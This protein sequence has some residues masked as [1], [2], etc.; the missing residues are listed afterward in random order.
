MQDGN[1][2]K[3]SPRLG[4]VYD[5]SGKGMTILR[6]GFGIFYDRPQGNMVFDMGGNAPGVLNS[7]LQWGLLQNLTAAGGDPYP[8]LGAEPDGVRLHAAEGL[9]VER[10]RAAQAAEQAD[11]RHRVRRLQVDDLLRQ[12]QINAVPLGATFLPQ[13]QDPTNASTSTVPGAKALPTDLLRPYQGYGAIRMWDYTGCGN[14]HALQTS[15]NRRFDNGVMFSVFYV[16]SKVAHR[17]Q[18]RLQPRAPERDRRADQ[19]VRLLVRR[20]RPAA[21]LRGQLHLPDAQGGGAAFSA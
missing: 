19:A 18:H 1:A 9:P 20:L 15:L 6:G 14:Y 10:R 11:L 21:Q 3:I 4:V 17:Q 13:N 16:W 8:T 5:I 2:F 7:S 12:Q